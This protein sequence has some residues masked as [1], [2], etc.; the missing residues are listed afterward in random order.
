MTS[1]SSGAALRQRLKCLL[2]ADRTFVAMQRRGYLFRCGICRNCRLK[3][4]FFSSRLR[5]PASYLSKRGNLSG[6]LLEGRTHA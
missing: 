6:R 5:Y 1:S 3:P 2:Y 4:R